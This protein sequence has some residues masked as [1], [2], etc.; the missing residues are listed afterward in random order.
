MTRA[1]FQKHKKRLPPSSRDYVLLS[2]ANTEHPRA[3][4]TAE[5][6]K[7]AVVLAGLLSP[8]LFRNHR[9]SLSSFLWHV[10]LNPHLEEVHSIFPVAMRLLIK[11]PI[12]GGS[13][14]AEMMPSF[15]V[16]QTLRSDL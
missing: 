15:D 14:G 4:S 9:C 3:T 6:L 2:M 13:R 10:L 11:R 16:L 8:C 5:K 12:V 7:K 1:I